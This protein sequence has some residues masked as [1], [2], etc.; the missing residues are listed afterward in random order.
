MPFNPQKAPESA[1]IPQRSDLEDPDYSYPARLVEVSPI[2]TSEEFN[3]RHEIKA[4]GLLQ[5]FHR[6]QRL[7]AVWPDGNPVERYNVTLLQWFDGSPI[8]KG[9]A[10]D[11][12]GEAFSALVGCDMWPG[13]DA[14]QFIGHVFQIQDVLV[15]GTEK[16]Y[17]RIPQGYLGD[18]S[19][20]FEGNIRTFT[21]RDGT[22][23]EETVGE[24]SVSTEEDYGN[25]TSVAAAISGLTEEA[26]RG[27]EGLKAILEDVT[28]KDVKTVLGK[29][30]RGGMTP[31]KAI[32][33]D[34][35]LERGLIQVIDGVINTPDAVA[36]PA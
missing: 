28:L 14:Q 29:S 24:T 17:M 30:L 1:S 15:P 32:L 7:D 10:A 5:L 16:V 26:A 9:G 19:F 12:I 8:H 6:F 11:I 36:V 2:Y 33:V 25:A 34:A 21:P 35:L 4:P 20:Q 31:P 18:A 27:G 23:P 22:T 3:K 13:T